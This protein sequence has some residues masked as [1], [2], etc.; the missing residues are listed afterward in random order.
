MRITN[1][2][3]RNLIFWKKLRRRRLISLAAGATRGKSAPIESASQAG[4]LKKK[5]VICD[6]KHNFKTPE[7]FIK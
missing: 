6:A 3:K 7:L 5:V 1:E 4:F 2:E